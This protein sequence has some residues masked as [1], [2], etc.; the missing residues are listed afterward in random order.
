MSHSKVPK[1]DI[2]EGFRRNCR[3]Y[4]L[5]RSIVSRGLDVVAI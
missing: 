1:G 3:T 5:V 2:I 4:K